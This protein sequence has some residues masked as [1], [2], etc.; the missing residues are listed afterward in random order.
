MPKWTFRDN[1]PGADR[2]KYSITK[3]E[4]E[5]K[6]LIEKFLKTDLSHKEFYFRFVNPAAVLD[7]SE[8]NKKGAFSRFKMTSK[9]EEAFPGSKLN[10]RS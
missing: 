5:F 2:L 10:K 8:F 3:P 6:A 4:L 7:E 1:R 9:E